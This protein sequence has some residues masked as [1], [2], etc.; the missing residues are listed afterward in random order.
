MQKK[1][2]RVNNKGSESSQAMQ[3]PMPKPGDVAFAQ[4]LEGLGTEVPRVGL[5]YSCVGCLRVRLKAVGA[6]KP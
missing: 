2:P 6:V 4:A 3:A 5:C 1:T